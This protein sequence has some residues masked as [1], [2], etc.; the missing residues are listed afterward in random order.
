MRNTLAGVT[1]RFPQNLVEMFVRRGKD[2][3]W[4]GVG[5]GRF[6]VDAGLVAQK[7]WEKGKGKVT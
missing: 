5:R 6:E 7:S 1:Q 2:G 3:E 4:G